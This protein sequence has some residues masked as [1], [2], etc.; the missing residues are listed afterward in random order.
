M[1]ITSKEQMENKED[2]KT[3]KNISKELDL[4]HSQQT[5]QTFQKG[6]RDKLNKGLNKSGESVEVKTADAFILE[7][8][9]FRKAYLSMAKGTMYLSKDEL[10]KLFEVWLNL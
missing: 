7:Y 6:S 9:K 5:K 2:K 1:V 10:I 8:V 3:L 4:E